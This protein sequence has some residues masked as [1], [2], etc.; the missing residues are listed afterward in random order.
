[1]QSQSQRKL[2]PDESRPTKNQPLSTQQGTSIAAGVKNTANEHSQN[3]VI[4]T[5]D[6]NY[7]ATGRVDFRRGEMSFAGKFSA[8]PVFNNSTQ[9][10]NSLPFASGIRDR[11]A[12]NNSGS[13]STTLVQELSTGRAD[14]RRGE[15]TSAGPPT[16]YSTV[17]QSTSVSQDISSKTL[18]S[19]A[20]DRKVSGGLGQS[21]N[22]TAVDPTYRSA[23]RADYRRGDTSSSIKPSI[24]QSGAATQDTSSSLLFAPMP[25]EKNVAGTLGQN[26]SFSVAITF[27]R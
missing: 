18:P 8:A 10:S 24:F 26:V 4:S 12:M 25:R 17:P 6:P 7:R 23:S 5:T 11:I 19:Y 16:K 21:V 20:S 13:N 1:M 27:P 2:I 3:S 22:P 15:T 9:D 14:F